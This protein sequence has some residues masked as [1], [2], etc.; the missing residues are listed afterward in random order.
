ML[1]WG[2]A[3][4]PQTARLTSPAPRLDNG[5]AFDSLS[6]ARLFVSLEIGC[7][8]YVKHLRD[9]SAGPGIS[10]LLKM[11]ERGDGKETHRR[12][13]TQKGQSVTLILQEGF[14]QLLSMVA[15]FSTV[16]LVL[17][18]QTSQTRSAP[19]PRPYI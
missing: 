12:L 6:W 2:Q 13:D 3:S 8:F 4:P 16:S 18:Q 7:S 5:A 19:D 1:S 15:S 17:F 10:M 11:D 9:A 14:G